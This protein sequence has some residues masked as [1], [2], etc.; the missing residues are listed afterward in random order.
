MLGWSLKAIHEKN[1]DFLIVPNFHF[2]QSGVK[3]SGI[4]QQRVTNC[5]YS[6][7]FHSKLLAL[8]KLPWTRTMVWCTGDCC[9]IYCQCI[10]HSCSAFRHVI[11]IIPLWNIRIRSFIYLFDQL[12]KRKDDATFVIKAS[13]LEIYNEKVRLSCSL[14]I[15]QQIVGIFSLCRLSTCWI[16]AQNAPTWLFAGINAAGHSL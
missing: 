6:S 4:E 1:K 13:Y 5:W 15:Y 9:M 8:G 3:V 7:F 10:N 2:S 14:D 12:E 16:R 11:D